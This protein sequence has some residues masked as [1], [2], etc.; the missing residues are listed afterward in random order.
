MLRN[1][2]RDRGRVDIGCGVAG[3]ARRADGLD[4]YRFD[5]RRGRIGA[6]N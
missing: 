5:M 6:R 4:W 2:L 3:S 1:A